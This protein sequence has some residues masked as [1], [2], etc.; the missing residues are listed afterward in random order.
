LILFFIFPVYFQLNYRV[1]FI[2]T[3]LNGC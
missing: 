3:W 1:L 2:E